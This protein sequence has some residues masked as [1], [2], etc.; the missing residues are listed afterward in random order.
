MLLLTRL[1]RCGVQLVC[2]SHLVQSTDHH[3][4]LRAAVTP[5]SRAAGALLRLASTAAEREPPD[6]AGAREMA[7]Q[8]SS[9]ERSAVG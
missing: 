8:A 3:K 1:C 2:I 5:L 9:T 4:E 7:H 6:F